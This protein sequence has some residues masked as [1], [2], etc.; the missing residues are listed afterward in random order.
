MPFAEKIITEA[1][2]L[3]IWKLDETVAGLI[4]QFRFSD[5]EQEAFLKIKNEKRKTEFLTTRLLLQ[6]LLHKKAEIEYL[7]SGK[8]LLKN[9][10]FNISISHSA[11]FVAVIISEKKIGIDIESINRNISRIADKF[12]SK[13]ELQQIE[14]LGHIQLSTTLYW[15]AK[16]AIF[17][18]SDK[19]GIQ[20]NE[21]I[22]ISPF[23]IKKEGIF[24]GT[25]NKKT[26]YKLW[27]RF[28]ENNIIVYC[29]E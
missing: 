8:P 2:I 25:L 24:T 20:F 21:Q 17:K 7:Q 15:S 3:G 28:Y 29:V 22:Y 10:N 12:L 26:E 23:E 18:C 4:P 27:Y 13:K 19:A 11:D 5:S 9:S 1:G 16:E 6:K 14:K